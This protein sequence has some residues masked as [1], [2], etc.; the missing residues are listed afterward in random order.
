MQAGRAIPLAAE[1]GTAAS[2][3]ELHGFNAALVLDTASAAD[4][5]SGPFVIAL[6]PRQSRM[7]CL[8]VAATGTADHDELVGDEGIDQMRLVIDRV[9]GASH[10]RAEYL[11]ANARAAT[12]E[13]LGGGVIVL[14]AAV[15]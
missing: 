11:Q 10:Q 7:V 4:E 8:A 14:E 9:A 12:G 5:G 6:E 15:R 1:A 3:A 2:L 13:I